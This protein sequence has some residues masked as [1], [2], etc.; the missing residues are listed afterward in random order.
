[1]NPA[2]A[3]PLLL[4]AL[5]AA[6]QQRPAPAVPPPPVAPPPLPA[7]NGLHVAALTL[8]NAMDAQGRVATPQVRFAVGD[9]FHVSVDLAGTDAAE[10]VLD[11]RWQYLDT[12]QQILE[13]RKRINGHNDRH[14]H[15]QLAKPDGW[16]PGQ[17]RLELRLDGQLVQARQFDVVPPAATHSGTLRNARQ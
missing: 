13:E 7:P 5:L 11:L 9:T 12:R 3:R 6:C 10:H 2:R 14:V 17:Y 1:M 15:F 16:P 4:A 8:G